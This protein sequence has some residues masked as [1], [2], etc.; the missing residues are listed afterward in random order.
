MAITEP[1]NKVALMAF[2]NKVVYYGDG[3]DMPNH[4]H[5]DSLNE[6]EPLIKQGKTFGSDLSLRTIQDSLE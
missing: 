3:Q 6:Y 1:Q 5:S 2:D 4:F